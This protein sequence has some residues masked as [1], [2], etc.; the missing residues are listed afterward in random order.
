M[1][2]ILLSTI[3]STL[4]P[5]HVSISEV[6]HNQKVK[7][8]EITMRIFLDDLELSIRNNKNEPELDLLNPGQNRTIDQLVSEYLGE[9]VK[10][11]VDKKTLPVNYLGSEMDG[12]ALICYIEV[13]NVK[14]FSTIEFT[15]RVI[16]ETHQDQSNLI[17]VNHLDKVKSLR[18]TNEKPTDV[19]S[20]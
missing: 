2:L 8:L 9:K 1:I 16:H 6:E 15:N 12:P 20:F 19:V 10:V 17:N 11:K 3:L 13:K 7:A 5:I 4:H 18:L 14:K